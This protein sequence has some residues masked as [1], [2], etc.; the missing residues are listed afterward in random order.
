VR[1]KS[2]PVLSNWPKQSTAFDAASFGSRGQ[3]GDGLLL[4][5]GQA[6]GALLYVVQETNVNRPH[7]SITW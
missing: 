7:Q 5:V 4:M 2:W 6:G 3:C 1:G